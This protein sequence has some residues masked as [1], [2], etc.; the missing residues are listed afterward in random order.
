MRLIRR[1]PRLLPLRLPRMD[2]TSWPDRGD[3]GRDSFAASTLYQLGYREAFSPEAHEI[4]DLLLDQV[5]PILGTDSAPEDEPYLLGVFSAAAQIGAGI[6]IVERS[7]VA[8][9]EPGTD[10]QIAGAL[11]VAADDLP[12]MAA[13]QRDVARFLLQCGYYLAR[14]E[15]D[16]I[17]LLV[18]ALCAE[19]RPDFEP[20]P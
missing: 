3:V 8:Q 16:R 19:D 10:R 1:R 6:G 18:A 4:T 15:L 12:F 14:T 2:G 17:P 7:V 20:E 11:W 5:V 13:H 9:P